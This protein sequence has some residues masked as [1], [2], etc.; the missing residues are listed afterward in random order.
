MRRAYQTLN[1]ATGQ[2]VQHFAEASDEQCASALTTAHRRFEDGWR[3]VSVLERAQ[4]I[5]RAAIIMRA[6]SAELASYITLEMGKLISQSLFEVELS[7]AILEYYAQS[8][9]E[10]LRTT[11]VTNS[12][13]SVII[14]EPIGVIMAVEPWNF[15]YYQLARIAGPQLV[16]GNCLIVKHARNVP[17]C[18]LAFERVLIE[19]GAPPGVYTNLFCSFSQISTLIDDFRIR[20]VTLTGSERAGASVAER[21]G[22]NLKKV[23]LELGGSDPFIVLSDAD[24]VAAVKEGAEGRL[25]VRYIVC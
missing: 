14:T 9:E 11:P 1:P 8:G 12:P 7:A 21:A 24:L 13:G 15:P 2:I 20:G 10:F 6:R 18:A 22:K 3:Y 17:Q 16:A 23:V 4:V 5:R 19:A 25:H